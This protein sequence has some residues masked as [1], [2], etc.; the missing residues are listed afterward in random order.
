MSEDVPNLAISISKL[1]LTLVRNEVITTQVLLKIPPYVREDM[2][3]HPPFVE[4]FSEELKIF[5]SEL[6]IKEKFAQLT[7]TYLE[8]HDAQEVID[9]L[10]K[11][12]S[13]QEIVRPWFIRKALLVACG[14]SNNDCEM[15]SKLFHD[16]VESLNLNY[17][18]FSFAFDHCIQN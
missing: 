2:V 5:D 16:L 4:F 11:Y 9:Q 7:T 17:P 6:E 14:R 15:T 8:T 10:K 3:Q 1:I 18:T 13:H 12:D